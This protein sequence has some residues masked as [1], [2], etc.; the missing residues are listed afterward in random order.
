MKLIVEKSSWSGWNQNYKPIIETETFE[1][2]KKIVHWETILTTTPGHIQGE[3]DFNGEKFSA[4]RATVRFFAFTIMEIGEDYITIK[5]NEFMNANNEIDGTEF[6]VT[7][8]A[9]LVLKTPTMDA[10]RIY[11]FTLE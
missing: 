11:T 10:G 1:D 9:P 2:L 3:I 7:K 6:K 5:T 8:N 4:S